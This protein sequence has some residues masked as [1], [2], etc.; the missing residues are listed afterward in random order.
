MPQMK[1]VLAISIVAQVYSALIGILLMPWYLRLMGSEAFGLIGLYILIQST[2]PLLELGFTQSLSREMSRFKAGVLSSNEAWGRLKSIEVLLGGLALVVILLSGLASEWLSQEWLNV[3]SLDRESVAISIVIMAL[4][5]GAR[6]FAGIYRSSL[7]GLEHQLSVNVVT[8][9]L[10][11]IRFAGVL[12]VL[13]YI[14]AEPVS[15]FCFQA[16]VSGLELLFFRRAIYKV[17]PVCSASVTANLNS[18][19][20]MWPIAGSMGFL[21]FMWIMITQI[22]K[23][24]LSNTLRLDEYGYFTLAVMLANSAQILITPFNQVIQPR[25]TIMAESNHGE[26]LSKLYRLSTQFAT[27]LFMALGATLSFFSVPLLLVWTGDEV[28]TDIAAPILF[29]YGFTNALVGVSLLPF[30]LQFAFGYLR[31]HVIGNLV[32]L[33][34][35]LP[36]LIYS[37]IEYGAVGVGITLVVYRLIYL[38]LWV[39]LIHKRLLPEITLVW[40]IKDVGQITV[41][42]VSVVLLA[43]I[44]MPSFDNHVLTVSTIIMVFFLALLTGMLAG[45]KTRN[46]IIYSVKEWM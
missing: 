45:D 8:A 26:N 33:L 9:L 4:A 28:A 21:G 30:M 43:S 29:W 2:L 38:L 34:T 24:V 23:L 25:M 41:V 39:P 42:V 3:V 12:P 18:L 6:W 7:V 20:K 40:P 27:A 15:F 32:L 44:V 16:A 11:T 13:V 46:A 35:L 31:L 22:D 17:L 10:A 1:S 19:R 14:S 36:T 37:A 5:T